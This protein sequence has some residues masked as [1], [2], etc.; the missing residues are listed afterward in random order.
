MFLSRTYQRG[1]GN[2]NYRNSRE[3]PFL[4]RSA[5]ETSISPRQLDTNPIPSGHND[6]SY[7]A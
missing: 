6:I 1:T 4:Y 3:Y 7:R 5:T 2:K